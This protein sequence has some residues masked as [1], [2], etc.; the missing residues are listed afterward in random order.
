MIYGGRALI[1]FNSPGLSVGDTITAVTVQW[2]NQSVT[3]QFSGSITFDT[4]APASNTEI[5]AGDYNSFGGVRQIDS[6]IALTSLSTGNNNLNTFTLNATGRGNTP[7][8]AVSKW[9]WRLASD[10]DDA[11][12]TW[13]YEV[14]DQ[15][16]MSTADEAESGDQRPRINITYTPAPFTPRVIMF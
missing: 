1:V 4:S 15:M 2:I 9:M 14:Q 5:A 16:R 13:A 8:N 10:F 11:P 3:A 6:D 12:V 7:K